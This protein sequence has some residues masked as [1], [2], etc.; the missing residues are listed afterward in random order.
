MKKQGV[1]G[2]KMKVEKGVKWLIGIDEVGRGPLAGPVGV[3]LCAIPFEKSIAHSY[4]GL[5]KEHAGEMKS[6][7][8]AY[9][10][11]KDSKKI[12]S[13]VREGWFKFFSKIHSDR[14]SRGC[15]YFAYASKS[16]KDIDEKGISFCI[17][18]SIEKL[19][20]DACKKLGVTEGECLLLLDGSL[21]APVR[22]ANQMTII[23]GDEKELVISFASIFAKVTR[24]V[25]MKKLSKKTEFSAYGF[26][27]H[28]GYGTAKHRSLIRK[29]GLSGEHRGTYCSA[30]VRL[31]DNSI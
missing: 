5:L 15:A 3:A 2:E 14:D 19:L 8:L 20:A 4:K 23:K 1:L 16:A 9:I 30:S 21:K 18:S 22:F 17:K 29:L 25:Y 11:G 6:A 13:S 12:K 26:D 28:K 24:D 7:G 31:V 27:V 10:V